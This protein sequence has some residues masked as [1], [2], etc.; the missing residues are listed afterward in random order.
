MLHKKKTKDKEKSVK[1]P[2]EMWRGLTRTTSGNL[3]KIQFYVPEKLVHE[4]E[5]IALLMGEN[6]NTP[7]KF[8]LHCVQEYVTAINNAMAA[9]RT[10]HAIETTEITEQDTVDAAV[11]DEIE[12]PGE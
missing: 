11:C 8:T 3:R 12:W 6:K 7:G 10:E 1:E 9:T 4:M 2:V 5:E